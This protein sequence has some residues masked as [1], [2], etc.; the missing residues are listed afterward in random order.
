MNRIYFGFE[1]MCEAVRDSVAFL[2]GRA[3]ELHAPAELQ[4]L[5]AAT[6]RSYLTRT[7][8]HQRTALK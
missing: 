3:P 4:A 2:L 8:L 7:S 5:H 1:E 6:P